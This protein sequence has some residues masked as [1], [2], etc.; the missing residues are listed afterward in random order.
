MDLAKIADYAKDINNNDNLRKWPMEI[1][2]I[3]A[4]TC[5]INDWFKVYQAN[6]ILA[7]WMIKWLESPPWTQPFHLT[8]TK[9]CSHST[10]HRALRHFIKR[11]PY[12]QGLR[13]CCCEPTTLMELKPI[14][15]EI[16]YLNELTLISSCQVKLIPL[17]LPCLETIN[18]IN[19]RDARTLHLHHLQNFPSLKSVFLK[20]GPLNKGEQIALTQLKLQKL[21]LRDIINYFGDEKDFFHNKDQIDIAKC[22]QYIIF[23]LL[24]YCRRDL[25]YLRLELDENQGDVR[26]FNINKIASLKK[27]EITLKL[28]TIS[29]YQIL[30]SIIH[31]IPSKQNCHWHVFVYQ[32]SNPQMYDFPYK[33]LN[34]AGYLELFEHLCY[35]TR[36]CMKENKNVKFEISLF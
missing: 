15:E 5:T 32:A 10:D 13:V 7:T 6:E 18:I 4:K 23:G 34:V 3:Y 17:N 19:D 33:R 28:K 12:I 24:G 26:L 14:I 20:G 2:K 21:K 27:I 22:S 25:E 29:Q 8:L 9:Y 1:Y 11:N 31:T 16:K 30:L 36:Q 35:I